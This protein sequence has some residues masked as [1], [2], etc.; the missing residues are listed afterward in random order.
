M[1]STAI[2][3]SVIDIGRK[4]GSIIGALFFG[5]MFGNAANALTLNVVDSFGAAVSD[6]RWV[7][8]E[9]NTRDSIPGVPANGT[10][11]SLT[12]HTSYMQV[13]ASGDSSP[14]SLAKLAALD[15]SKRYY[16]SI[17]PGKNNL[18]ATGGPA[19]QL[20]GAQVAA[21]KSSVTVKMIKGDVPTGQISVFIFEDNQPINGAPDLPQ[22]QGLA[23]FNLMLAEAGGTYGASGGQVTKNAYGHPI[24]TE[25]K[26]TVDPVTH[27]KIFAFD[28]GGV[29]VVSKLGNGFVTSGV[30]GVARFK[31]LVPAKYTILAV[32]PGGENS[33]L[34][35]QVWHQTSTI[36]GTKGIDAWPKPDEPS[37]F[38]EFGPPGHHVFIGF[39]KNIKDNTA[40]TGA[41]TIS[42][43][44]V[45]M[46]TARPP[47]YSFYNG[48]PIPGCRVGLN[49]VPGDGKAIYTTPCDADSKFTIPNVPPGTYQL[50]I[51]DD[52][53]DLVIGLSTVTVPNNG[54]NVNLLDVP[55]F[56][57][58][59]HHTSHVFNDDNQNGF[60]DKSNPLEVPIKGQVVN[61]RFRDG[62]IYASSVTDTKGEVKFR[63]TFPFFNWMIAEVDYGRFKATGATIVVDDGG[64]IPKHNGWTMPSFDVLSPQAQSENAGLPF[65]TE[66][67]PVLLE[68]FQGFLGTTNVIEWGKKAYAPGENGGIAGIVHYAITRAENDPRYAAA[69]NWEPGIPRVQVNLYRDCNNDRII[70][71]GTVTLNLNGDEV[72]G[73]GCS[74][75]G[76]SATDRTH[77]ADVDNY[78]FGWADGTA[79]K[80]PEDVVNSGD[81]VTFSKGWAVIVTHTDSWD[82]NRPTG[83]QGAVFVSNGTT[84][85]CYD[86]LRNFNQV[87]PAVFDGGYA[88]GTVARKPTLPAGSYVIEANTPPGYELVKEEDKNVNFGNSYV[89]SALAL[90]A[91]CVGE[92]HVVPA[93][94]SLFAGVAGEF[95]GQTRPLCDRKV[96]RVA[97]GV[98]AAA[99]FFLFTETPIAGHIVGMILDD[100]ANE[101]DPNAP[102][103][104]ERHAPAWVPVSIRDWTGSEIDRVYADQWGTYNALVPSTFTINPAMPSG[105][106]PNMVT[107]CMNH[108]GP[109][110]DPAYPNDPSKTIIDPHFMRQY[111]Q[112][113]YTFQY[114]PGKTTYLDTPVVPVAAFAGPG[115]FPLDCE[116]D[117]GTPVIYSVNGAVGGLAQNGPYVPMFNGQARTLNIISVGLADVSNPGYDG[118]PNTPVSIKRDFGFGATTGTVKLN[119]TI[120]PVVSWNNDIAVVSVPAGVNTG[121]L[122]VT[123]GDN[124]KVTV[125]GVT[126]TVGTLNSPAPIIVA[127]KPKSRLMVTGVLA[128]PS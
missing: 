7:I 74:A 116:F 4:L 103:F 47:D 93:E 17:M 26:Y 95:A 8:E 90:P 43:R 97:D 126:V 125:S 118:T 119:G 83:C 112:F 106:G 2:K 45:N 65:R 32:A 20:G 76:T 120:L 85:D 84:T 38:Q 70:D 107:A 102:T 54:A 42:G 12:F 34:K 73:A 87:R 61:I 122:E 115:Q 58:F 68:G 64:P 1:R 67:G 5:I 89:P 79:A 51:W 98:N 105:L 96:V 114:L 59:H 124:G 80:G 63:E 9:N 71:K 117:Y 46:H 10:N 100:T 19:Y 121:Q 50:A 27:K 94:L 60:W 111:S 69:E 52:P 66:T 25:Y 82:D 104:G 108:A 35:D 62:S 3:E 92:P 128:V 109:I 88:F 48:E 40:L 22:E 49:R 53:L 75:L 30:D 14:A 123:R 101:F 72:V 77:L 6:Y 110:Q 41:Q 36:E 78:P 127:P 86:G 29:P 28:A 37:F 15:P 56:N 13:I 39:V 16:I 33:T 113:C 44:I 99:D 57:W 31:Y 21:G 55:V 18:N 11:L 23:G 91:A 24:G 81:G